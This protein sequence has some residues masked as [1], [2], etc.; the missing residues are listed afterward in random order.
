MTINRTIAFGIIF[1]AAFLVA[2]ASIMFGAFRESAPSAITNISPRSAPNMP[3]PT[4][5][6]ISGNLISTD[7]EKQEI[8]LGSYRIE[9]G[10]L[11]LD[12]QQVVRFTGETVFVRQDERAQETNIQ[13][14]DVRPNAPLSVVTSFASGTEKGSTIAQKVI[15]L[16][17]PPP[18]PRR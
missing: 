10:R 18:P 16:Y 9:N 1:L 11:V 17:P 4:P 8:T 13:L 2:V 15:A 6:I 5:K 7:F 14:K 12:S 3:P